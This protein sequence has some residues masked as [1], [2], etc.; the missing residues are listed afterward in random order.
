MA[1]GPL[2]FASR[3]GNNALLVVDALG[4]SDLQTARHLFDDIQPMAEVK[5]TAYCRYYKVATSAELSDLL[6]EILEQ[7]KAGLKPI[8]HIEAHGDKEGGLQIAATGEMIS[9]DTL[10]PLFQ[11]INK[12]T[13][14]NL[15]VV[16]AACFGLH[17]I[18]P[19]RIE[20]PCP[21]YF[22]IGAD[23][24]VPAGYI[25]DS[26]RLFY[27]E[28]I[29]SNSLDRAMEKIDARFRQFHSEKFFYVTFA[30]YMK[31]TCMGPGAQQRVESLITGAFE[32]GVVHNRETLRMLRK[33]AKV[34]VKSQEHAFNKRAVEFLHGRRSV[35]YEEFQRFV[36]G[37]A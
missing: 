10:L 33:N 31:R 29:Q 5:R 37:D 34:L 11:E 19:L 15:G 28:L 17:A 3:F 16:L 8:L 22:L 26:M 24:P 30:K 35:T 14:N 27:R 9:W 1:R 4:D 25:D 13:K 18:K 21:F 7:C 2:T 36:R 23:D 32:R 12:A 6:R 20:Q